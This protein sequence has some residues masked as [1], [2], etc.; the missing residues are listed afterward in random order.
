MKELTRTITP[1][2]LYIKN[3]V[4]YKISDVKNENDKCVVA[5]TDTNCPKI[6][7]NGL[8]YFFIN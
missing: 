2:N 1:K 7:V 3:G 4:V 5:C 6:T 8:N